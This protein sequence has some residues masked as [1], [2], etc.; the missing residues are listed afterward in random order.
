MLTELIQYPEFCRACLGASEADAAS[1]SSGVTIPVRCSCGCARSSRSWVPAG[2]SRCPPTPSSTGPPR[3]TSRPISRRRTPTPGRP[4]NCS[5]SP[6]TL[7]GPPTAL[8]ALLLGRP[9]A[10][11]RHPLRLRQGHPHRPDHRNSRRSRSAPP[12]LEIAPIPFEDRQI[13]ERRQPAVPFQRG[14]FLRRG[15][16]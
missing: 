3:P 2:S 12:H 11:R 8:R 5:G 1:S 6:S 15:M 10:A 16:K 7:R 13:A 4:S 9:G 14:M